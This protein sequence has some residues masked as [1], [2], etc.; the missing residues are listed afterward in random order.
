MIVIDDFIKDQKL[1]DDLKND[2]TFFSNPSL[3]TNLFN[4]RKLF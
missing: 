3:I 2:K 4:S 1:L